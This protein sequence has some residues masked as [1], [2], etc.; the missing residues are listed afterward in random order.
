MRN[1]VLNEKLLDEV[2][3]FKY[4]QSHIAIERDIDEEVKYEIG[5]VCGGRKKVLKCK[6]V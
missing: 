1:L 6:S 5:E 4:I 3:C 2:E